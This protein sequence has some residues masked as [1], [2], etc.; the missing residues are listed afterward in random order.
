[1]CSVGCDGWEIHKHYLDVGVH[2]AVLYC[3]GA[4]ERMRNIN[5]N[6]TEESRSIEERG[7][8]SEGRH[9]L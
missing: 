1:M 5:N 6:N 4:S 8:F 7:I 9:I 3:L 2:Y